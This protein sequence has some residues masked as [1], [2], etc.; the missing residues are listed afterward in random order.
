[1]IYSTLTSNL[2]GVDVTCIVCSKMHSTSVDLTKDMPKTG[3]GDGSPE[4]KSVPRR[5]ARGHGGAAGA[6]ASRCAT[7][8]IVDDDPG[9]RKLL[10][11][12]LQPEGYKTFTAVNG[13]DALAAIT[14]CAPDLIL[15]DIILPGMDGYQLA[16]IL[17]TDQATASIPIIMLSAQDDDA[18]RLAGLKAGAEEFLN[19][20]FNR[21]ELWLRVRNML[22][23]KALSDFFQAHS[24]ILEQ[25]VQARTSDVQ[26]LGTANASLA[27]L[28]LHDGLTDLANR[29]FFDKYLADQ[30]AI[31]RRHQRPLALV[32][33]D[34]DSFKAFN[35]RYGHPAG[36]ECLKRIAGVLR[37]SC[38]RPADMAARY[39][40]EEFAMILPDTELIGAARVGEAARSAVE[41]LR[42]PHQNSPAAAYASVS[43]G[44]ALL[45]HDDD[46]TVQQLTAAA[47]RALYEAKQ[48][49]RNRIVSA[50]A[51]GR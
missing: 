46:M 39:G 43:G 40:G 15:L 19:K 49:G 30:I 33:Y 21:A 13:E 29:R 6:V 20:P 47:D 22:R 2:T 42:I 51:T 10:E 32:M 27:H 11:T 5:P 14:L 41:G 24:A 17:K 8:L 16:S 18:A 44:I 34:V 26:R 31:A 35:D 45:R 36:D 38:R 12:L 4:K 7:I 37:S 1:M 3:P 28:S 50:Q 23:L 25:E 9:I 48:L